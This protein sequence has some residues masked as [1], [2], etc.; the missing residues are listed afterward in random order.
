[1]RSLLS[2][3]ERVTPADL[4]ALEPWAAERVFALDGRVRGVLLRGWAR[5]CRRRW[6]KDAPDRVRAHL[7]EHSSL[8]P[9]KPRRL[10]WLPV[11]LQV[12]V[13]DIIIGELLGGDAL[14]LDAAL[15]EDSLLG[16]DRVVGALA[17][18]IGPGGL[19]RR[20][21]EFRSRFYDFGKLEQ[22]VSDSDAIVRLSGHPLYTNPTWRLMQLIGQ[23]MIVEKTGRP[24]RELYGISMDDDSYVVYMS[25]G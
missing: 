22:E 1:M 2:Q 24:I 7:G 3:G 15:R 4:A 19:V 23:R 12:R 21:N 8:L 17:K 20:S 5:L 18:R 25:W 6:G 13:T 16:N 14:G 10:L 11:G 9:D